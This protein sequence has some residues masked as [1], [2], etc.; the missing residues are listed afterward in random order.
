MIDV[1]SIDDKQ[2]WKIIEYNL[3]LVDGNST[4]EFD[5]P[6]INSTIIKHIILTSEIAG[7]FSFELYGRGVKDEKDKIW[8]NNSS[9][10]KQ[11]VLLGELGYNDLDYTAKLHFKIINEA[12]PATFNLVV[13][14]V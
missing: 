6:F 9:E 13:K 4:K 1:F 7:L 2:E 5:L 11:I 14:Y 8:S 3:G 12:G 10:T